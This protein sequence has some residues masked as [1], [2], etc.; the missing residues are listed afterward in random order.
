MASA[1]PT[2]SARSYESKQPLSEEELRKM[3]AYWRATNYLSVGQIYLY[4]NPLL[5]Q[6]LKFEH[7]KPRLLMLMGPRLTTQTY[8]FAAWLATARP[9]QVRLQRVGTRT[10][11]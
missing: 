4:A 7:I 10:S 3:H 11:S 5:H 2:G 1:A 6:P 8:W 9:R